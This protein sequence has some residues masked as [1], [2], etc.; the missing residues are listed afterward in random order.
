VETAIITGQYVPQNLNF[1]IR[2][3]EEGEISYEI[4]LSEPFLGREEFGPYRTD[5]ELYRRGN[6]GQY[7]LITSGMLTSVNLN[8]DRDSVMLAGKDWIHY[9]QR[10]VYPFDP[11]LYR[12]GGWVDWPKQWPLIDPETLEVDDADP[13]EVK[14]IVEGILEAMQTAMLPA[15]PQ[16]PADTFSRGQL[17]IIFNNK[18]TGSKTKYKIFPGDS[19]TIFDHI[20]K[21]SEMTDG[22]E[23]DIIPQSLE[24][25]MWSP[26]RLTDQPVYR[27]QGVGT[28]ATGAVVEADWTND[29]PE[30][31]VLLGLGTADRKAGAMWYYKPSVDQYRWLDKVYDF[32]ELS[33]TE[34]LISGVISPEDMLLRMLK[35]Q[36]DLFPQR[37]LGISLLNPEFLSPSFY[38]AGRP[39]ALI[40]RRVNFRHEWNPYW[41]VNSDYRVN[42]INWDVDQ[43]G[44]EEVELELEILYEET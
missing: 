4:P 27:F 22:F 37:K 12:D 15:L 9:L 38:T 29:G 23:F 13:V 31:T 16:V 11:I 18:D 2:N 41:T 30:G 26:D 40:G 8:G 35:D 17:G 10:R 33:F 25:K 19:T 32:G 44:N 42:A 14:D 28:E 43:N 36:D 34:Q 1:S 21:L 24:F 3:S 20:K 5:Y 6:S 39:R 7:S